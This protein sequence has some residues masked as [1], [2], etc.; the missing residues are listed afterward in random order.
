MSKKK[1]IAFYKE[2]LTNWQ[3]NIPWKNFVDVLES[4]EFEKENQSGSQRA[5]VKGEIRFTAHEPHGKQEYVGREDRKKAF[6]WIEASQVKPGETH[7][8]RKSR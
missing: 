2:N 5:F 3:V 1:D 6:K 8:E 7:N 4:E